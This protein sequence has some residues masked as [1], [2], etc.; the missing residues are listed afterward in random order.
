MTE[1][2]HS[3]TS[4]RDTRRT[5]QATE[6]DG[7]PHIPLRERLKELPW[8]GPLQ[9]NLWGDSLYG[10][11]RHR[12]TSYPKV[13]EFGQEMSRQLRWLVYR[14]RV[15]KSYTKFVCYVIV[16]QIL[17]RLRVIKY[18]I[19]IVKSH[20]H[21]MFWNRKYL[22]MLAATVQFALLPVYASVLFFG[23]W[24]ARRRRKARTARG[25]LPR[26]VWGP[27]PNYCTVEI[28]KALK[29]YGYVCDSIAYY[30]FSRIWKA[31]SFNYCL[32]DETAKFSYPVG[33]LLKLI[34]Y[35][36]K[37]FLRVIY[38]YDIVHGYF[39]AGFLRETI[40]EKFEAQLLHRAG[41]KQIN[42]TIGGDVAVMTDIDS[43][44]I[45][46]GMNDMYPLLTK[47]K[48]QDE[49]KRW[50]RYWTE[51]SDYIICQ[52][53]YMIDALPRW[54]VL[55]TQYFPI[56]TDYWQGTGY[57]DADG[58]NAP[59]R[60]GHSPNHRP[61]K[62]S[63]F[64]I[65]AVNELRREGLKIE[66]VMLENH[67]NSVVRDILREVD[68]IV[69][70]VMLQGYAVMGVEGCSLGKPVVQDVSDPH[71]NRVFKLYT[72]LDEAPFVSVPLE[73][74]KD[75]L[76]EL[77]SNPQQ[78]REIGLKSRAYSL[79]YHSHEA[80]GKF[81][82]WVYEHVWFN[83]R[84]RVAFYHP[85]WPLETLISMNQIQLTTAENAVKAAA[86][87]AL[88]PHRG[89]SGLERLAF[90]PY[91][92]AT[93]PLVEQLVRTR[94]IRSDDYLV[95]D[96]GQPIP[97]PSKHYVQAIVPR[98]QLHE[99]KLKAVCRLPRLANAEA[100]VGPADFEMVT[101]FPE[102]EPTSERFAA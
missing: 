20:L 45:R 54:D 16:S 8:R 84:G 52:S 41:C 78:R 71:Y 69:A 47:N 65:R 44:V 90:Y 88:V 46:Q 61:L 76:R 31:N 3:Q 24:H 77:V 102:D 42:T 87:A 98:S 48:A 82:H 1:P 27:Y 91:N 97:A 57:G 58:R 51:H 59:V 55:V 19:L 5:G 63:N 23:T 29:P 35:H 60:I 53:S 83:R 11:V 86:E 12:V 18:K 14:L 72:G 43:H 70:D 33:E 36:Y 85:D 13:E 4:E 9:E 94:S 73:Q 37:L 2:T 21:N 74:L 56:D 67:Q 89:A 79:K 34:Y 62:G 93:A 99:F 96:D 10:R 6:H 100:P 75:K 25:E 22:N 92:A 7:G 66:L 50:I 15:A 64:L 39:Y 40:F 95:Y 81:W 80:N 101:D 17:W 32:T 30:N 38:N 26:L 28:A 49:I 68:I